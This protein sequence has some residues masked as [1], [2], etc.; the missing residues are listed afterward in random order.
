MFVLSMF[1]TIFVPMSNAFIPDASQELVL[2]LTEG[3]HL[4]LAPPGCGK[5]QIL[6]ERLKKACEA[7]VPF[8]EMLCLT[9][10][11]RAARSMQERALPMLS[12][13]DEA[14]F[15]GNVHRFCSHFLFE[16]GLIS[17]ATSVVSDDDLLSI[18]CG[19]TGEDEN[20]VAANPRRKSM[21][22]EVMFLEH[23]LFQIET[24]QPK[25]LRLHPD[26]LNR[27]DIMALRA[28]CK[29]AQQEFTPATLLDIY[30]HTDVYSEYTFDAGT[31]VLVGR[32]LQKMHLA[33]QYRRY[34][35][36]NL[37]I[38][39]EDILLLAYENRDLLPHY[40]WIQ[41]D[42]V[43]D[44]NPLQL[45][46]IDA[47]TADD[48][49]Q[50]PCVLYLGDPQQSIFSFMGAKLSTLEFL[51]QRCAGQVHTLSYNHRSPKYL[52]DVFNAYAT[53][54]LH[55]SPEL[56]PT[57][58]FNPPTTGDEL[59]CMPSTTFDEAYRDVAQQA[60]TWLQRFP[61]ERTAIIVNANAD[62]NEVS[63]AL[64][65]MGVRH[66]KISGDDLFNQPAMKLLFAHLTVMN[67]ALNFLAWSRI[68]QGTQVFQTPTSARNFVQACGQ[69]ALLLPDLLRNDD[70]TY[71][72]Y[73]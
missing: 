1:Y 28:L 11:N 34:K 42:E 66:F 33:W 70:A 25:V 53:Q 45:A 16:K 30:A 6:A 10:T 49:A 43:Q 13:T 47:L 37:L 9:F 24:K 15:M 19:F 62:A 35:K 51:R 61:H 38:D 56:L 29:A 22:M 59:L 54:Q 21:Y 69:R 39:F 8:S 4:V 67:D 52:L 26:C 14:P 40:S 12:Q 60:A 68:V 7:G 57:T 41:V 65:E 18:L 63:R 23:L 73:L 20:A 46:I 17:A 32:L 58:Q 27:E 55:I 5:T 48:S 44:L 72:Q 50:K 2:N 3:F 31:Q 64:H 36:E 71:V